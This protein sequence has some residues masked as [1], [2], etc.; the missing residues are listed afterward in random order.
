MLGERTLPSST[1]TM[2]TVSLASIIHQQHWMKLNGTVHG[3]YS[4]QA[5]VTYD[6]TNYQFT[7]DAGTTYQFT[8]TS[9]LPHLGSVTVSGNIT[10]KGNAMFGHAT[11]QLTLTSAQGQLTIEVTGPLQKGGAPLPS[12]FTY[13]VISATGEYSQFKDHGNISL[14]LARPQAQ[15]IDL[16]HGHFWMLLS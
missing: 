4:I 6:G 10:T 15:A 7:G 5:P 11:G 2:P 8:A 9:K 16:Q 1:G 13:Q 14:V 12:R 3:D